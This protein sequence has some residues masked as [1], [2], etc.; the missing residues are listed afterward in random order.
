MKT[1]YIDKENIGK[2]RAR[3]IAKKLY[4]Q[5]KKEDIV[6]ALSKNLMEHEALNNAL[7]EYELKVLNDR[8]LFKFLLFDILEYIANNECNGTTIST[9]YLRSGALCAPYFEEIAQTN[10]G[11]SIAHP[12]NDYKVAI[13]MDKADEIIMQQLV[14]IAKSVKTLKIVTKSKN[15]YSY[16]ENELFQ[17]DGIAIQITNNKEKS[18]SNV[19]I[20]LNFDFN[21]ER[22]SKY[23]IN[24]NAIIIDLGKKITLNKDNFNGKI[25][26]NYEITFNEENYN[27]NI[28]K[29]NFDNSI[30][31]ESYIYRRDTFANIKNQLNQ[32]N[33]R[34]IKLI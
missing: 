5:S 13:L 7:N 26:N 28:N 32:D 12:I 21:E 15:S 6:I 10:V 25:I 30:L 22:I 24:H 4:K 8:W 14:S 29:D 19:D 2:W 1:I 16:I 27:L 23:K 9:P 33:V 11:A 18:L 3:R 17:R 34:L 20:I 31:Y